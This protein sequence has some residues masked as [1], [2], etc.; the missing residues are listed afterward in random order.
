MLAPVIQPVIDLHQDEFSSSIGELTVMQD[1]LFFSATTEVGTELWKSDGTSAGT[2][3]VHDIVP[4]SA[5]SHPRSLTVVNDTLYF[6]ISR[7]GSS[8]P[9]EIWK[10]DGTSTGTVLVVGGTTGKGNLA[11]ANGELFFTAANE[12]WKTDGTSEG[13]A[14][15][16]G[17]SSMPERLFATPPVFANGNFYFA[18]ETT[19][20]GL[21]LWKSD[22]TSAGTAMVMD[23]Y[24]GGNGSTPMLLTAIGDRLFFRANVPGGRSNVFVTDG[25]SAGTRAVAPYFVNSITEFNGDVLLGSSQGL[26]ELNEAMDDAIAIRGG[27]NVTQTANVNGV[28]YFNGSELLGSQVQH[29]A[30][31][32]RS[33]GTSLGTFLV[34]DLVPGIGGS[35]PSQISNLGGQVY[36]TAT[37]DSSLGLVGHEL[38]TATENDSPFVYND[39]KLTILS[40]VPMDAVS[41]VLN[42]SSITVVANGVS[43]SWPDST[44]SFIEFD[45]GHGGGL[46]QFVG[47]S[48]LSEDVQLAPRE[49]H[50]RA[51]LGGHSLSVV[52]TGV[53][54]NFFGQSEDYGTL[55]GS[56]DSDLFVGASTFAQMASGGRYFNQLIGV[57]QVTANGQGGRDYALVYDSP[58]DD[59]FTAVVADYSRSWMPK[60]HFASMAGPGFQIV[61][62]GFSHT[63]GFSAY[64]GNDSAVLHGSPDGD[65]Y[66]ATESYS[67]LHGS[68]FLP[69]KIYLYYAVGF[70]GTYTFSTGGADAAIFYGSV[71]DDQFTSLPYYSAF[72]YGANGNISQVTGFA[73]KVAYG[74]EGRDKAFLLDQWGSLVTAFPGEAVYSIQ[75]AY[76]AQVF[77]FDETVV[78]GA[79]R[80]NV[81]D[82]NG[83]DTIDAEANTFGFISQNGSALRLL[84]FREIHA[85][86]GNGGND[87]KRIRAVDFVYT[88]SGSWTAI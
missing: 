77:G 37:D 39:G 15:I 75:G 83:D 55:I 88:D 85:I 21:E 79:F 2:T 34:Q 78:S 54:V 48:G 44:L 46:S 9:N 47:R 35:A 25:T 41:M 63:Y 81:Y 68:G 38:W 33:D 29:G 64:G 36:F 80:A 23:I 11:N 66:V 42:E 20:N 1:T 59:T 18:G 50:Y 22:G 8:S 45:A 60:D 7:P 12:L 53:D 70:H 3:L 43:R 26:S 32:W 16:A 65:I 69:D 62:N 86:S 82:T 61:A 40:N 17:A 10:T 4:G 13:T 27:V 14:M 74:S 51:N 31:L 57:S 56:A 72:S 84:D 6:R 67:V 58:G 87:S 76:G 24:P 73:M 28:L 71:A 5:S 19:A 52:T 49:L 30:E